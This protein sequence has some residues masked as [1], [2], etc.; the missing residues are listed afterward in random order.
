MIFRGD[1]PEGLP[2]EEPFEYRKELIER[3]YD[4]T[5]AA[6]E[7]DNPNLDAVGGTVHGDTLFVSLRSGL[8]HLTT[9]ERALKAIAG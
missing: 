1:A 2:G 3:N 8:T 4:M 6:I 7:V 9:K 5:L